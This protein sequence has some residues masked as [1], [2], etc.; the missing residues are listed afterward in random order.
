MLENYKEVVE[1]LEATNESA[2]A[3]RTNETFRVL[4]A[5]SLI[6]LPLTLIASVFGMN[7][8]VPGEDSPHA[9]WII[10]A[11][12]FA[13]RGRRRRVLPTPRMALVTPE[14]LA[15]RRAPEAHAGDH[16]PG[17]DEDVRPAARASSSTRCRAATTSRRGRP[18][19]RATRSSSAARPRPQGY[20]VVVAFGGD[21]T[22]NEAANGLAGSRHRADRACPAAPTTSWP[23][24]SASR[25][26]SSTPPS[27][28]CTL[29]DRWAPR[30]V[31]LGA[32]QRP[33]LHVRG[34]HGPGR[35]RRRARRLATR[36]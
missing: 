14:A 21:G 12:M 5:I 35:Q 11:V 1:G 4:T 30:T 34:R 2:I 3:H 24:C 15:R 25:P 36:G 16:Q 23:S 28:C 32:G 13:D 10:M 17:R 7:V 29:A 26:T 20:D 27:T 18:T 9:F 6:F 31:D 33:L 22:V 19:P 8:H